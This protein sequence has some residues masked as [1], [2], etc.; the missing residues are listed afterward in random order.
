[1]AE[2]ILER[3]KRLELRGQAH[4]LKARVLL[5]ANGLTEAVEKEVSRALDDA[6]LVKIHVPGDDREERTAIYEALADKL[7]AQL[8][9]MENIL[10][11]AARIQAIGKML[12]LWRPPVEKEEKKPA[13]EPAPSKKKVA[14]KK[15]GMKTTAKKPVIIHARPKRK[16]LTK[17]AALAKC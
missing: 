11:G 16:T 1:M 4:H 6:G 7:G 12:V 3:D 14:V 2:L 17:K 5:G 8:A 10:L 15:P 9:G 13:F